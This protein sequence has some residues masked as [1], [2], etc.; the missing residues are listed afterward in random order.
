LTEEERRKAEELARELNEHLQIRKPE[1]LWKGFGTE[2][3][4]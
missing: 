4:F 3:I 2:N 1:D